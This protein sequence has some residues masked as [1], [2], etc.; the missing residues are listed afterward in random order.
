METKIFSSIEL[1]IDYA[2]LG[3]YCFIFFYF[4]FEDLFSNELALFM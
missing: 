1:P 2:N 4:A 3:H